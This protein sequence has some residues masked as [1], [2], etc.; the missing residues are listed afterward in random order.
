MACEACG[1][2]FWSGGAAL[3]R[4]RPPC[5]NAVH[6]LSDLRAPTLRPPCLRPPC[7]NSVHQPFDLR[8]PTP[9]TNPPTSV[10]QPFDLR[11]P[12]H[13]PPCTNP[14]TSVHQPPD[15]RAPPCT[16]PPTPNSH[17]PEPAPSP[18]LVDRARAGTDLVD[19]ARAG[20]DLVDRATDPALAP[21]CLD[22]RTCRHRAY[23]PPSHRGFF[24]FRP[25]AC[26]FEKK[27]SAPKILFSSDYLRA[28][29]TSHPPRTWPL[30]GTVRAPVR[31]RPR[32][33]T[34]TWLTSTP[35]P[36]A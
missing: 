26:F 7:T 18:H 1:V 5:T 30:G 6:Q 21:G 13:R 28:W 11:A 31:D 10:H 20:T 22:A 32:T 19:R 17:R 9:C 4:A 2:P 14:P 35:R 34:R 3:C 27:F 23:P 12:T 15:L 36:E 33:P 25:R 29:P 24:C 16:N 8:A